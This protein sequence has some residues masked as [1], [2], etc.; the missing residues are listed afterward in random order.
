[1]LKNSKNTLVTLKTLHFIYLCKWMTVRLVA[2][3][4]S[5]LEK[6]RR[7]STSTRF[8]LTHPS[9]TSYHLRETYQN[10]FLVPF[11]LLLQSLYEKGPL[12]SFSLFLSLSFLSLSSFSSFFQRFMKKKSDREECAKALHRR[13][14]YQQARHIFHIKVI[15]SISS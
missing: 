2:K 10:V 9:P 7:C 11:Y 5:L 3:M 8:F 1:M 4:V 6:Q 14:I 12:L 13:L 15:V